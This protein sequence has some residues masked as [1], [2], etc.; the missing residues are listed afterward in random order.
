MW[1]CESVLNSATS[2]AE[3]VEFQMLTPSE[4]EKADISEVTVAPSIPAP[5]G[6]EV[7][8]EPEMKSDV[9]YGGGKGS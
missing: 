4:N 5:R 8:K 7:V 3:S 1:P 9:V 6:L 2:S